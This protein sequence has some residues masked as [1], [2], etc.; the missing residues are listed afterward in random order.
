[1]A[2][3][4]S[5]EEIEIG[6]HASLEKTVAESDVVSFANL[7]GDTNPIHLD[8]AYAAGTAFKGRIVHGMLSAALI[9]AVLGT[10]LPGPGGVYVTQSLKF[11]APVRIGDTVT[12]R[13]ECTAKHGT[14]KLCTFRTTCSVGGKV[15]LAGEAVVRVPSREE[16]KKD[17]AAE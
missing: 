11:R 17:E 1:M 8:E 5:F 13:V 10:R 4:L 12:A 15:V 9:S 14:W 2:N 3:G 16:G 7:T 6:Q